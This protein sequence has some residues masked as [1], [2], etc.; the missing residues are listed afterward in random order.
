MELRQP[1]PARVVSTGCRVGCTRV[2]P[3]GCCCT[4]RSDNAYTSGIAGCHLTEVAGLQSP[5]VQCS[6]LH[7]AASHIC[8]YAKGFEQPA[9][10]RCPTALMQ[11]A[12]WAACLQHLHWPD[13]SSGR[14]RAAQSPGPAPAGLPGPA[15]T[16][17]VLPAGT[18]HL[19]ASA[20]PL[21]LPATCT[22]SAAPQP[23]RRAHN[24]ATGATARP[25]PACSSP[26][27]WAPLPRVV[28]P[29]QGQRHGS[30]GPPWGWGPGEPSQSVY[31]ETV[32]CSAG[33]HPVTL[34]SVTLRKAV[35]IGLGVR[36]TPTQ[37]N[38]S[39]CTG[40]RLG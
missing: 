14:R 19:T 29:R 38:L 28:I 10:M 16:K 4:L 32:G 21:L 22:H 23:K 12:V 18:A 31:M 40:P 39:C 15:W 30:A 3:S 27:V 26:G 17:T 13:V 25:G 37:G 5:E 36:G 6:R 2:W 1:H 11:G 20:S 9:G 7:V 35:K 24:S 34:L 8:G 33:I